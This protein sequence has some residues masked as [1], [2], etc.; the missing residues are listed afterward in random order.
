VAI[1]SGTT[2]TAN[3]LIYTTTKTFIGTPNSASIVSTETD[4]LITQRTDNYYSFTITVEASQAGSI[5]EISQDTQFTVSPAP[6]TL[7]Y[8]YA[9]SDFSGGTDAETTAELV[10]RV[11]EGLSETLSAGRSSISSK[12]KEQYTTVERVSIT[13]CGDSE[14]TRDTHSIIPV[15]SGARADI[16]V[17]SRSYPLTTT[18]TKTGTLL[19]A[20][21]HLW[22]VSLTATEAAG[23]YYLK[24]VSLSGTE[25]SDL[26][27]SS[28]TPILT[29]P[30]TQ[31]VPVIDNLYEAYGSKYVARSIQFTDST[32]NGTYDIVF[33]KMPYIAEI[34]DYVR[35]GSV[36][37]PTAD[38]VV[39]GVIP[40]M[41]SI[42]LEISQVAG[43]T[44]DEAEIL[45]RIANR[46]NNYGFASELPLSIITDAVYDAIG[47][48]GY[49][50][51][52][53]DIIGTLYKPDGSVQMQASSYR[54][55]YD[56][57]TTLNLSSNTMMF[58]VDPSDI[59]V[60][61]T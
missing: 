37:A 53:M 58:F 44:I 1:A 32:D 7:V 61:I 28:N 35:G 52:P 9:E 22:E 11:T 30:T 59:S 27:V 47:S 23:F 51:F 50:K 17:Q 34:N 13:G 21:T 16:W 4:R 57:S 24:R 8:A 18:V 46:V 36:M 55:K 33:L 2:F 56:S 31:P 29:I 39:R 20:S 41:L 19:N 25:T 43:S 42:N 54:L 49:L 6:S 3:G 45:S 60:L 5:Y 40:C 12:I 14:M 15:S 10:T 48:A 38:Y 26:A